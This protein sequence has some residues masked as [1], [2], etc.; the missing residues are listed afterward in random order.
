MITKKLYMISLILIIVGSLNWFII[1]LTGV[2]FIDN[3][4]VQNILIYKAIIE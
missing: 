2:N 4:L 1:G 3:F